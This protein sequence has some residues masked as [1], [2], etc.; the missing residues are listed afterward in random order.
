MG[1]VLGMNGGVKEELKFAGVL[2]LLFFSL[3]F[4]VFSIY[5]YWVGVLFFCCLFVLLIGGEGLGLVFFF[6]LI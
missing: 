5:S 6:L 2:L 4:V 1:R 3:L